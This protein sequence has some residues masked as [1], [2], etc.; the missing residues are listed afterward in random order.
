MNSCLILKYFKLK[1]FVCFVFL[2][3]SVFV[4]AQEW[5]ATFSDAVSVSVRE[6]KPI[7]LVFSGSDWCAPCIKL[8]R[9]IWQSKEFTAYSKENYV[10]YRADFPRKK[11]NQLAGDITEQNRKLAETYNPKGYFPLVVVLNPNKEVLGTTGYKKITPDAYISLLNSF[12][13]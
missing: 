5:Q 6:K 9:D 1:R 10:L 2:V 3:S 11:S 12:V 13:K 4:S 7:V 8:E